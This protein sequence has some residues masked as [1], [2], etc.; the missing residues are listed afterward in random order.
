MNLEFSISSEK[1]E[2][3]FLS[4]K[5]GILP[6]QVKKKGAE[7][8]PPQDNSW[9]WFSCNGVMPEAEENEHWTF[10]S[11]SF[12]PKEALL[13]ELKNVY[14]LFIRLDII[15]YSTDPLSGEGPEID[16]SFFS[17]F[18]NVGI[19]RVG[20]ICYKMQDLEQIKLKRQYLLKQNL[21][22]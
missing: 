5:L 17:I 7:N 6:Y 15:W 1:H 19:D 16:K 21:K 20:I 13:N 10:F 11:Q 4:E 9:E 2:L 12:L 18:S 8:R 22:K 14:D 3:A